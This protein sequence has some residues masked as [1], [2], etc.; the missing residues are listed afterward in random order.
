METKKKIFFLLY[1][2][3]VGGVEKSFA[4]LLSVIPRDKY[5]IHVGLVLPEGDLMS[6][7][8][9]DVKVHH[10]T[11][12]AERWQELKDP[13]LS[14]IKNYAIKGLYMKTLY[15]FVLYL[16]CKL[17]RSYLWWVEYLLK[18]TEGINESFD[19][20]V[21]YA[22]P[23]TD[24]DYYIC[25]K[26]KA[27]RK[28]GWVH[29]DISIFNIDKKATAKYYRQYDSIYV[30]SETGQNIFNDTFPEFR[31]KTK[32]FHNVVSTAQIK[33]QA[34]TG[35]TYDDDYKGK[36]LLTVGRI[37]AEKGQRVAIQALK[38]LVDKGYDIHW[39][40]VGEGNDLQNCQEDIKK[41]GLTAY[42]TFLG[43]KINP[44]AF[45]R[46]CDVYVQPSRHEGFC[47]TLAE[48]LCFGNP[49]VSTD[50][51]GAREQLESRNNGVVVG[52]DASHIANGVEEALNLYRK[53]K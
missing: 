11:D 29:F 46:D 31:N 9:A 12:L 33:E 43:T 27:L 6:L 19:I 47:I 8:P 50:F 7:L 3:H 22:G 14:T 30:V 15:A 44:Y 17:Q 28:V 53:E 32:V 2:M 10:V 37:S 21:A 48:A 35:E 41:L 4:S 36:R 23:S 20:A 42:V 26:V 18:D 39:Y 45:M 25:N 24:I 51:T 5:D 49:I 38:M 16:I 52:M 40:F 1:S 34:K 13:P